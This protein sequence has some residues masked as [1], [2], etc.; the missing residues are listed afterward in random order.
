MVKSYGVL[1][2]CALRA[3]KHSSNVDL[4]NFT[5]NS[6][7]LVSH[8]YPENIS[9]FT[10]GGIGRGRVALEDTRNTPIS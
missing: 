3:S 5:T 7:T 9:S 8:A 6:T 1:V 2:P 10:T 4:R